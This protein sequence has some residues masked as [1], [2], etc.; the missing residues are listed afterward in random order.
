MSRFC[1][2]KAEKTTFTYMTK[3]QSS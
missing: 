1:E 3:G 2:A